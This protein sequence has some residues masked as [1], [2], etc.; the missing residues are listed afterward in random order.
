MFFSKMKKTDAFGLVVFN[1]QAQVL[2]PLQ[3]VNS[4]EF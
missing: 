1:T 2:I 4:I 3:K